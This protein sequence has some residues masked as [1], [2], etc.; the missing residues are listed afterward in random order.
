MPCHPYAYQWP[1]QF[2]GTTN[3]DDTSWLSLAHILTHNKDTCSIFDRYVWRRKLFNEEKHSMPWKLASDSTQ[4]WYCSFYISNCEKNAQT[5]PFVPCFL[6]RWIS[7]L[8]QKKS[9]RQRGGKCWQ[10]GK[11]KKPFFIVFNFVFFHFNCNSQRAGEL[12]KFNNLFAFF[13]LD[14]ELYFY[15]IPIVRE[16]AKF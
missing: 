8:D 9:N 3:K 13:Y 14:F 5:E 1:H 12:A 16:L 6:V 4:F 2:L 15:F 11:V 7:L 10:I